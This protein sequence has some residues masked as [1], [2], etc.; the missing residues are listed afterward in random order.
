[1]KN[2][3]VSEATILRC[4]YQII[5]PKGWAESLKSNSE[6]VICVKAANCRTKTD[7]H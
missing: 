4:S 5:V 6:G 2:K 1:M 7:C 3:F